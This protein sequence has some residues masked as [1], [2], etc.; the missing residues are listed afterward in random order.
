MEYTHSPHPLLPSS[1]IFGSGCLG[2]LGRSSSFLGQVIFIFWQIWLYNLNTMYIRGLHTH[3]EV[4]SS[5]VES[6][7]LPHD[8]GAMRSHEE[9][10]SWGAV[11]SCGGWI[12]P[13]DGLSK[14][15][16]PKRASDPKRAVQKRAVQNGR[17]KTGD[18]KRTVEKKL[19]TSK[20]RS[21]PPPTASTPV[22]G[23]II[24]SHKV[25]YHRPWKKRIFLFIRGKQQIFCTK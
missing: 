6:L 24:L 4:H 18:P 22:R 15:G 10:R 11:P 2:F 9:L 1:S 5:R 3:F 7:V 16:G 17:S 19:G 21:C 12:G 13:I 8:P 20:K 25:K 23:P 14:T